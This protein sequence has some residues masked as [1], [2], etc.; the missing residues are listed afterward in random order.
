[1][2]GFESQQGNMRT[3]E[4]SSEAQRISDSAARSIAADSW[5][6]RAIIRDGATVLNDVSDLL[7]NLELTNHDKMAQTEVSK[8]SKDLTALLDD[9]ANAIKQ[10]TTSGDIP[11]GGSSHPA[12]TSTTLPKTTA[13]DNPTPSSKSTTS[14]NPTPSSKPTTSDNPTPS[15]KPTTSDNPTPSS[16]PTPTEVAAPS[17]TIKFDQSQPQYQLDATKIAAGNGNADSIPKDLMQTAQS[18]GAQITN[19]YKDVVQVN[20]NNFNEIMSKPLTANTSYVFADGNYQLGSN[21]ISL[22]S[23]V[24]F[25]AKDSGAVNFA[26]AP[27]SK[28]AMLYIGKDSNNVDISGINFAAGSTTAIDVR[29]SNV[30]VENSHCTSADTFLQIENGAHNVTASNV[31]VDRVTS[32]ALYANPG[33]SGVLLD[34][35][36]STGSVQ[37][38]PVRSYA[39]N[40]AVVSSTIQNEAN[41]YGTNKGSL[42]LYGDSQGGDALVLDSQINQVPKAGEP[43]SGKLFDT[44]A[45]RIGHLEDTG[46]PNGPDGAPFKDMTLAQQIA[47]FNP[48]KG[49]IHS[50]KEVEQ[51]APALAGWLQTNETG[52]VAALQDADASKSN[53]IVYGSK[54]TGSVEGGSHASTVNVSYSTLDSTDSGAP[55]SAGGNESPVYDQVFPNPGTLTINNSR[56]TANPGN[57][58]VLNTGGNSIDIGNGVTF[59]G[60]AVK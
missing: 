34:H 14:D 8:F 36:V 38:W 40:T 41:L 22:P 56:I 6:G 9:I 48:N 4:G 54:I 1:M 18:W 2:S 27:G 13:T 10:G 23:D 55:F 11:S 46:F 15:S 29:G 52:E 35:F 19:N 33:A 31:N 43:S 24:Q 45:L 53:V 57:P 30:K 60:Q 20:P 58:L 51:Q 3:R 37:Q 32:Y 12:D 47:W 59:N 17:G 50:W 42:A 49:N 5:S 16:K 7:G 21:G 26:A 28:N 44:T 25:L 39:E